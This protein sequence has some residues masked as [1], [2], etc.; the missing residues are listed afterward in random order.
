[1]KIRLVVPLAL[2]VVGCSGL[3]KASAFN[4]RLNELDSV[5]EFNTIRS[6]T[7]LTPKNFARQVKSSH[8]YLVL[9]YAP[10]CE[11]CLQLF[12]QWS[13]LAALVS[14]RFRGSVHVGHMDCIAEEVFCSRVNIAD[15]P[16]V[17]A[18][19]RGPPVRFESVQPHELDDTIEYLEEYVLNLPTES[20]N[21]SAVKN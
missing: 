4:S 1:M 15:Y 17:R 13:K 10:W 18:Y 9:F 12:P 19:S 14:Q 20:S 11:Y 7:K 8:Y 2:I 5:D 3:P 6:S 21:R 16:T